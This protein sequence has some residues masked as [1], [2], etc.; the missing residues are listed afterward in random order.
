VTIYPST[1]KVAGKR[2]RAV[3]QYVL[4][5]IPPLIDI[6]N[7]IWEAAQ[8]SKIIDFKSFQER[9]KALPA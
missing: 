4:L 7:D 1:V 5:V 3:G 9:A 2:N 8:K 6:V